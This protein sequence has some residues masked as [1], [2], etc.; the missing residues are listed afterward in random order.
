MQKD[1]EY[2]YSSR[3]YILA[4]VAVFT[5]SFAVGVLISIKYPDTSEKVLEMIKGTYGGIAVLDPFERMLLIFKNNV[6][7][8]FVALLLGIGFGIIPF[9]FAALNGTVLGILVELFLKK[10]GFFFVLAAI[11]PHGIIE[12]PMI[13]ISVGIGF[14]LG[15]AAYLLLTRM[16]TMND[17]S[18][19]LEQGIIFYIKIVAPLLLMAA[20]VESY[21]TPLIISGFI[22]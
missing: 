10:Q 9:A 1:L 13:F 2:I 5:F 15:H 18:H 7:I 21:L 20:F 3:K 8:S 14:R 22:Q 16:K 19:E 4:A 11:L 17:L 12:L 6:F